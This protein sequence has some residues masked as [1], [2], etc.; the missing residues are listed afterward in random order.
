MTLWLYDGN[1]IDA[2]KTVDFIGF[3]YIG[4]VD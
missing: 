2:E 4:Y 1:P 3:I